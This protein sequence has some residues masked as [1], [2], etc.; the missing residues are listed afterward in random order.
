[1]LVEKDLNSSLSASFWIK[2]NMPNIRFGYDRKEMTKD[3]NGKRNQRTIR[4]TQDRE[5]D[6]RAIH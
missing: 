5:I 4:E 1:M 2:N 3:E 6:P